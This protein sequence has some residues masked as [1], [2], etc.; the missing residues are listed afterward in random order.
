MIVVGREIT[1]QL[2]NGIYCK[3]AYPL[4]VLEQAGILK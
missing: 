1:I 2:P 4:G 3:G